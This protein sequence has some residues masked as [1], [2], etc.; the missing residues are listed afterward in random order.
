MRKK[1]RLS[2]LVRQLEDDFDYQYQ[3]NQTL[4]ASK[5]QLKDDLKVANHTCDILRTKCK[6]A[7]SEADMWFYMCIYSWGV[8]GVIIVMMVTN[9]Y[10]SW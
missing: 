4:I 8:I 7:T 1:I 10:H 6:A 2:E 3:Y 9:L 5:K